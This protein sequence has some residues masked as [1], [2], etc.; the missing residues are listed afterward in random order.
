MKDFFKKIN[1]FYFYNSLAIFVVVASI[2]FTFSVQFRVENMQNS[3]VKTESE[4]SEFQQK[5]KLLEVEWTYLTRPERLRKLA[6]EYLQDNDYLLAEQ[7][8][9]IDDLKEYYLAKQQKLESDMAMN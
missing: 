5:I 2:A 6:N 4:I 1:K 7:I 9:D 3:I 8:K